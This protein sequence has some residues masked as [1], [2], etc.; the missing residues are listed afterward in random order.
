MI[1]TATAL[2]EHRWVM[3]RTNGVARC[4]Q[5]SKYA[6]DFSAGTRITGL[7]YDW[8]GMDDAQA[9]DRK[10][11]QGQ[12]AGSHARHGSTDCTAGVDCSGLVSLAWGSP[13][14]YSTETID[15]LGVTPRYDWQTDMEPGDALVKPG[16]HIVLFAAYSPD[17]R[18][19]VYEASSSR[20][21]VVRRTWDWARL[22][23]YRPLQY[24]HIVIGDGGSAPVAPGEGPTG[25]T[26]A[27][28]PPP[29]HGPRQ[30]I[31]HG[32]VRQPLRRPS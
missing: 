8:G 23:G 25:D 6:S 32:G 14:K 17:G 12:A 5:E 2:A 16:E 20:H 30:V 21:K 29:Q 22:K 28:Q 10:L 18:P 7:A 4:P 11:A 3:G 31:P 15:Q 26:A 9:F 1:A 24:R 19:I 13:T 27:P